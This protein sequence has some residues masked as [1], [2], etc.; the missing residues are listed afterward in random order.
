MTTSLDVFL[1]N[2]LFDF[3]SQKTL[4]FSLC[5]DLCVYLNP[6]LGWSTVS[7]GKPETVVGLCEPKK[8]LQS[9]S[10]S[11]AMAGGFQG[12]IEVLSWKMIPR[13]WNYV[14]F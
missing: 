13:C 9:A 7:G 1:W 5:T 3:L 12:V 8:T 4:Y 2:R 11:F 14:H 10:H 6:V